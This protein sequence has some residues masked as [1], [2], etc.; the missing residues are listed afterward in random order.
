MLIP[1]LFA[2]AIAV[3]HPQK[4][5]VPN[6]ASHSASPPPRVEP[7]ADDY[8]PQSCGEIAYRAHL[9]NVKSIT[10]QIVAALVWEA[11]KEHNGD[12]AVIRTVSLARAEDDVFGNA[13]GPG[14][15]GLHP[16]IVSTPK[17]TAAPRK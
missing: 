11:V 15:F 8:V 13:H 12:D 14:C 4:H 6:A 5:A 9:T 2:V 17:P 3:P 10:P 1:L 7:V 16:M